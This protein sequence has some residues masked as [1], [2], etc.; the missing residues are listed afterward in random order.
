MRTTFT[1]VLLILT[2]AAFADPLND[3]EFSDFPVSSAY[4][5][6]TVLPNWRDKDAALF[7]TRITNAM[8]TGSNFAG[9]YVVITIGCGSGGCRLVLIADARNGKLFSFPASGEEYQ[10]LNLLYELRSNL[11]KTR[12][13]QEGKCIRQDFEWANNV[14][15]ALQKTTIGSEDDCLSAP[16]WK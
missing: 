10:Y 2:S 1:A 8:R 4:R 9:H 14:A 3:L 11:I 15:V 16:Q 13:A 12:Y 7:R 5:G 6:K